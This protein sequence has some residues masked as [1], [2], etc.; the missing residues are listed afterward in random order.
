M[1]VSI[2]LTYFNLTKRA[3]LERFLVAGKSTPLELE[4]MSI[5]A[6]TDGCPAR[7]TD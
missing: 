2:T 6:T 3:E 7:H 4:H 1:H 5:T